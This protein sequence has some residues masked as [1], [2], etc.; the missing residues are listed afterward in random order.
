MN[1]PFD[2]LFHAAT[3]DRFAINSSNDKLL[4]KGEIGNAHRTPRMATCGE[5]RFH[6]TDRIAHSAARLLIAAPRRIWRAKSRSC[7]EVKKANEIPVAGST[8]AN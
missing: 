5:D 7:P 8:Q 1:E 4:F 6:H 2:F 3:L